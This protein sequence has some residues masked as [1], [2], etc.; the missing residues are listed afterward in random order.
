MRLQGIG[1]RLAPTLFGFQWIIVA[2]RS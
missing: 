2:K 1:N